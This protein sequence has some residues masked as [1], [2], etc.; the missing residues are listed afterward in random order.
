MTASDNTSYRGCVY[1]AVQRLMGT[2]KPDD[3]PF[4]SLNLILSTFFL[5]I[6]LSF[7]VL[8]NLIPSLRPCKS[9][10]LD[11]ACYFGI[12]LPQETSLEVFV[13][14]AEKTGFVWVD[15]RPDLILGE[16]AELAK[17]V[18][19][20]E[21]G[22]HKGM[23]VTELSLVQKPDL[24]CT[25]SAE[26]LE[27][28]PICSRLFALEYRL[29]SSRRWPAPQNRESFFSALIDALAGYRYLLDLGFEPENIL[30]GGDSA[31]AI[32]AYQLVQ[33]TAMYN[34]SS[35]SCPSAALLLSPPADS[36]LK[37]DPGNSMA[38]NR[39]SDYIRSQLDAAYSPV[40]LAGY[41]PASEIDATWLSPS[42]L[43]IPNVELKGMFFKFSP[44]FIL[45]GEA[46]MC[47]ASIRVLWERMRVDM[48]VKVTYLEVVNAPHDLV[49]FEFMEPERSFAMR[50]IA[51]WT[52]KVLSGS[53]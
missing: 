17:V 34:I 53:R 24:Y 5:L 3:M 23:L 33:Y 51:R 31:S 37:Q 9:W 26:D 48:G 25:P 50:K 10:S 22:I 13:L 38:T 43:N 35:L 47:R 52:D 46:K 2:V 28:I 49:G 41:L 12:G 4:K 15:P 27:Y 32:I 11:R 8:Q 20:T 18:S 36:T 14:S 21:P 19:G 29:V 42:S 7:W 1:S 6:R 40:A 44:T 30:V 45:A 39:N 16:I